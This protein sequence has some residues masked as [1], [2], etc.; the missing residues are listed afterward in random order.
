MLNG[1]W[2]SEEAHESLCPE[3]ELDIRQTHGVGCG[4]GAGWVREARRCGSMELMVL[5]RDGGMPVAQY[6]G[7]GIRFLRA[8]LHMRIILNIHAFPFNPFYYG[9]LLLKLLLLPTH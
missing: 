7:R 8:C 1:R 9:K 5:S 6:V 3:E 2:M 4:L